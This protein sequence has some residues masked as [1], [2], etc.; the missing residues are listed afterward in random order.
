MVSGAHGCCRAAQ[1][2]LACEAVGLAGAS[3][4]TMGDRDSNLSI[5]EHATMMILSSA[6]I[7]QREDR[8]ALD[9]G[10]RRQILAVLAGELAPVGVGVTHFFGGLLQ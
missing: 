7:R 1:K 4:S 5:S 3:S 2:T 10:G 6:I 8:H 9:R